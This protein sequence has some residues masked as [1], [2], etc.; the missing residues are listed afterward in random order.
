M[1]GLIVEILT[2]EEWEIISNSIT[3]GLTEFVVNFG[4]DNNNIT[5]SIDICYSCD[6]INYDLKQINNPRKQSNPQKI[7]N[8]MLSPSTNSNNVGS[9]HQGR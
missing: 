9:P 2:L 3:G 5:W 7:V 6:P 8:K 4:N 1:I